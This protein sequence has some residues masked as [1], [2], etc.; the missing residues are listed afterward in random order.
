MVALVLL[1]SGLVHCGPVPDSGSVPGEPQG[2]T[3]GLL[4]AE[5]AGLGAGL[6]FGA[7]P[8]YYPGYG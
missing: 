7:Y 1:V 6:A 2:R 8:G 5:L 3:F 4:A